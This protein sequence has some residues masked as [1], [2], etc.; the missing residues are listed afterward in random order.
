MAGQDDKNNSS[1][2]KRVF[3]QSEIIIV[4]LA[5]AEIFFSNRLGSLYYPIQ[6]KFNLEI[7]DNMKDNKLVDD[8]NGGGMFIYAIIMLFLYFYY[9]DEL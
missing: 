7:G 9:C 6:F 4:I 8:S 5:V 1:I 3:G 2:I